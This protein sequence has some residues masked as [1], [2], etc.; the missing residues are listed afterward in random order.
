MKLVN[1]LQEA[2]LAEIKSQMRQY[3]IDCSQKYF[4]AYAGKFPM[5]EFKIKADS[6]RAGWFSANYIGDQRGNTSIT[7]NSDFVGDP[8]IVRGIIYHETIHYYQFYTYSYFEYKYARDGGHDAFFNTKMAEINSGEGQELVTRRQNASMI[9][10]AASGKFWA[11]GVRTR[12]G[13]YGFVHT[14]RKNAELID[15]IKWLVD[16]GL[17]TDAYAFE[18][19]KFFFKIGTYK[20]GRLRFAIPHDQNKIMNLVDLSVH[21][22][23]NT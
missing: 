14:K 7:I 21:S 15:Y 9:D 2:A 16:S 13:E 23:K 20:N 22:L 3:F 18:T 1:I 11:Y 17:Y 4:A 19:D 10:A 12:N 6:R 8:E 5:P